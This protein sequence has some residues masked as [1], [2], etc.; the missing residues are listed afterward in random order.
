MPDHDPSPDT[1]QTIRPGHQGDPPQGSGRHSSRRRH[2]T[3]VLRRVPR[4][5]RH[6]TPDAQ[7]TA[8]PPAAATSSTAPWSRSRPTPPRHHVNGLW[9]PAVAELPRVDRH[10]HAG[11]AHDAD[12]R[13][14][15]LTTC[16]TRGSPTPGGRRPRKWLGR[17]PVRA[18]GRCSRPALR[19]SRA[20]DI[21]RATMQYLIMAT[22]TATPS[23]TGKDPSRAPATYWESWSGYIAALEAPGHDVGGGS[24]PPST[25]TTVRLG[26][27]GLSAPSRTAR[28][29]TRKTS[30]ATSSSTS[31]ISTPA[32][33]SRAAVAGARRRRRLG[34]GPY[35]SARH[36]DGRRRR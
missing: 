1:T 30:A 10:V 14:P 9:D 5:V 36:R 2:D 33:R 27:R 35:P 32:L 6:L 29:P 16:A 21:R 23:T 31:P 4:R 7:P 12:A 24:Q 15:V 18:R 34:R 26:R 28:S 17:D 20:A 8:T 3:R 11:S 25:A 22:E 19:W 13:R